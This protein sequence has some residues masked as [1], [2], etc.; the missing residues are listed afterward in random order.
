MF[1]VFDQARQR[2]LAGADRRDR[3]GGFHE[4]AREGPLVADELGEEVI[5]RAQ[6]GREV[7]G[8]QSER[9]TLAGVLF[10]LALDEAL[11]AF[12]RLPG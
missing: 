6:R 12:A 11:Q 5:G 10:G 9:A 1:G 8:R 3:L 2:F 4:E 7:F